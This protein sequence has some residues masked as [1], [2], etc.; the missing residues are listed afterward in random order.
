MKFPKLFLIASAIMLSAVYSFGQTA[1]EI[2]SKSIDAVGGK[3]RI[4]K[5]KSIYTESTVQIMGNDTPVSTT[6]LNGKGFK[7]E[8]EFNGS[9]IVQAINEK[10]GWMINPMAGG[11][12]AQALSDDQYKASKDQIYVGGEL[13]NYAANDGKAELLGKDGD[14]YKINITAK[15][16]STSTYFIDDNTYLLAKVVKEGDMMGQ[17]V[18]ITISFS[19]YQ[20]TDF[21]YVIAHKINTDMGGNYSFSA[22]VNKVE[23]NKEIDP[24]IFDMPN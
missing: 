6:I 17:E 22:T 8:T 23:I 1:D 13:F 4:S 7:S 24:E 19:D 14:L 11:T 15:D 5:I 12:T 18:K 9:K 10:G 21:G 2:I 3:E 20:T 16:N